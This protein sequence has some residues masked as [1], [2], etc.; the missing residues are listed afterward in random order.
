MLSQRQFS[1]V[2]LRKIDVKVPSPGQSHVEAELEGHPVSYDLIERDGQ[3]FIV[4]V[5]LLKK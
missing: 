4:D 3:W 2:E 1:K 5:K